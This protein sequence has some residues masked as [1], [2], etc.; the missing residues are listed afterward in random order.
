MNPRVLITRPPERAAELIRKLAEKQISGFAEPVTRT[1]FLLL[2]WPLPELRD[3]T[4]IAFTSANGVA[5]FAEL[6]KERKLSIPQA[7][8]I[9]VVG[10]AT[11]EV[12]TQAFR[13]PD[14]IVTQNDAAGLAE[15]LLESKKQC[16][17]LNILWP[18]ANKTTNE[19]TTRLI[20]GHASVLPLP[21]Y[22]T[23]AL[24]PH[25]LR[26]RL[27]D[28]APWKAAVFA[29]PSAV[30]AFAAAW[31]LPWNFEAVAIGETTAHTLHSIKAPSVR[32]S[33]SPR[34]EDLTQTILDAIQVEAHE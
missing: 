5:A 20:A 26:K 4:W 19:F 23:E 21:V 31:P 22:S 24:E 33:P 29:A 13:N 7:T 18:C 11:A 14:L 15:A 25:D 17:L 10:P 3:Y 30:K 1:V 27:E 34:A 9:A 32:V 2:E 16:R 28:L 6:L 12:A 8:Q